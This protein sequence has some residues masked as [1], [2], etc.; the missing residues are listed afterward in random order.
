M[1]ANCTA[2]HIVG[3]G[4]STFFFTTE[5]TVKI[6]GTKYTPELECSIS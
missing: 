2:G 1:K 3:L 6:A 5:V 4:H